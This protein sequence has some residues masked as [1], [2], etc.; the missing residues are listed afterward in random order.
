M[1]DSFT[2][3]YTFDGATGAKTGADLEDLV[4]QAMFAASSPALDQTTLEDDGAGAARIKAGG[5]D[6]AQIATGALSADATGLAK[7]EDD[8][9]SGADGLAKFGDDVF[10]ADAAG[11]APF[12]DGMVSNGMLASDAV[13]ATVIDPGSITATQLDTRA[14]MSPSAENFPFLAYM[15]ADQSIPASTNTKVNLNGT[16]INGGSKFAGGTYTPV[17]LGVYFFI[18]RVLMADSIGAGNIVKA[19]IYKNG[20]AAHISTYQKAAVA[21]TPMVMVFGMINLTNLADYVELYVYHDAAVAKDI[22]GVS[23]AFTSLQGWM[24]ST[25]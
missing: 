22:K 24:I 3:G 14:G 11:R 2:R 21:D 15:T 25:P 4:T 17:V 12:A 18:G 23:S 9:F 16:T 19:F 6:T 20:V 1:A 5:V 7:M 10:T 13:D 8:Y